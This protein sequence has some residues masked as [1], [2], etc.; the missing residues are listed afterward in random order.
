MDESPG[1]RIPDLKPGP[2]LVGLIAAM[3]VGLLLRMA[4]TLAV[5]TQPVT[6]FAWYMDRARE[7]A[8]GLGYQVDGRA[9]AYWPVGW[10]GALGFLFRIFGDGLEVAKAFNLL[11]TFLAIPLTFWVAEAL[12]RSR[13]V[14]V[15]AAWI[16]A[17]HPSFVAYSGI[18]ASEPVFTALVLLGLLWTLRARGRLRMALLAGAVFGLAVLVRPQAALLPLLAVAGLLMG[19]GEGRE[20]LRPGVLVYG[21]ILGGGLVVLPWIGR[22]FDVFGEPVFVSTNGGDNLLIGHSP[23][24]EGRW[25][26][27]DLCGLARPPEMS[28]IERDRAAREH[29]MKNIRTRPE[30]SQRL[31]VPKLQN[32][33][34]LTSDAA[35]WAFQTDSDGL[36]DPAAGPDRDRYI[37]LKRTSEWFHLGLLSLAG[38]GLLVGAASAIRRV[39]RW[40]W[41][42]L[43]WLGSAALVTVVFFGNPRFL[44][45]FL[46]M[47]A[48]LAGLAF[49]APRL[50]ARVEGAGAP[51]RPDAAAAA[52]P[53]AD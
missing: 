36:K 8:E 49:T 30:V 35:Y 26:N 44:F 18:L 17:L 25:R 37:L 22:N 52:T 46:P 42:P 31:I 19:D 43:L 53:E 48:M 38:I 9:T 16:I 41:I 23:H 32:T 27:P 29:A 4:F 21:L 14:A 45:P 39:G 24:S 51:D 5:S 11:M 47:L 3:L 28:E 34:L 13:T 33:F 7:I 10:P 20:R 2:A 12:F 40:A 50:L 6:D 1:P 15:A